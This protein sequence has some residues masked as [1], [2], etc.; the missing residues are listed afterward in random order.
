M[1]QKKHPI[2]G[3]VSWRKFLPLAVLG[4]VIAG[5]FLSGLH[6]KISFDEIAIRYGALAGWVDAKP[7]TAILTAITVYAVATAISFPAPWILTVTIGLIFGWVI[8]AASIVVGATLGASVLFFVTRLALADFFRARAG[9]V[10]NRMAEGFRKDAVSY[11]LFLRLAPV[12]PFTLVNVVPAVLG[13]PFRIFFFTTALGIVPGTIA[14]TFAG[15][16]LRSIVAER[17]QAC[18]AGIPPCGQALTPGDFVTPQVL[19]ALGLLG[20]VSLLPVLVKG[21]RRQ[22]L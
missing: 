11:M 9:D 1:V 3:K 12:F 10:L 13:V 2:A 19:I 18:A 8:G 22:Q 5:F 16:G 21:I 7:L 17:A 20:M 6:K 14:Y 4:V 15:E